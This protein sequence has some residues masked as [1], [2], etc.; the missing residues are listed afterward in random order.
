MH[1]KMLSRPVRTPSSDYQIK[2]SN[3]SKQFLYESMQNV[4]HSTNIFKKLN[5]IVFV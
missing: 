2:N 3:L 4:E 5:F 1:E